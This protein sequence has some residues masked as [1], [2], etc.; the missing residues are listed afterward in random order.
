MPILRMLKN[1]PT[2]WYSSNRWSIRHNSFYWMFYN[3]CVSM[4]FTYR[5]SCKIFAYNTFLPFL[6]LFLE[7]WFFGFSFKHKENQSVDPVFCLPHREFNKM[8]HSYWILWTISLIFFT[9]FWSGWTAD[10][11]ANLLVE[12]HIGLSS[13]CRIRNAL[14][15]VNY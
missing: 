7:F 2:V 8:R 6:L 13:I 4:L 10:G 15:A 3:S 1:W 5:N 14:G 11:L 12:F 9:P